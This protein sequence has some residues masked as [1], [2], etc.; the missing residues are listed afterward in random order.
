MRF[1]ATFV[2]VVAAAVFLPA[3]AATAGAPPAGYAGGSG[4]PGSSPKARLTLSY[5]AEAGFADA[6]TL[7][8]APVGGRHPAGAKACATLA[9]AGGDPD[10]IPPAHTMCMLIYAPVVAEVSGTWHGRSVAWRHRYGNTCE[11]R[12]A[13]G[14]VFDF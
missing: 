3:A 11:M 2:G 5:M 1:R 7:E 9:A 8:C 6:V 14:V 4:R 10:R 12:R 13:T